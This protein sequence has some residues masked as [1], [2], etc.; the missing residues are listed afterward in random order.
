[1]ETSLTD[2]RP[3]VFL[4]TLLEMSYFPLTMSFVE[5]SA[6]AFGLDPAGILKL[7]LASEEIFSYLAGTDEKGKTVTIESEDGGY[8]VGV[9][10]LF[11]T[12][13]FDPHAFNFTAE[14]SLESEKGLAEMGLLIAS[15]SVNRLEMLHD[16]E[17]GLGIGLVKE[18]AYPEITDSVPVPVRPLEDFS[19][20]RP[21]RESLKLFV[22]Q[23]AAYYPLHHYPSY[24]RSPGKV[25][26][27]VEAGRHHVLVASDPGAGVA[28]GLM[29]RPA[30][31]KM[32]ALFGPYLFG[33]P[34]ENGMAEA[35]V[36]E[37][38]K[39]MAKADAVGVMDVFATPELPKD[40]F[41]LLGSIDYYGAQGEKEPLSYFFRQLKEDPGAHVWAH[42]DLAPFLQK[43]YSRLFLPRQILAPTL[44]GERRPPRSVFSPRFNRDQSLVVLRLVWD[45]T[46][47]DKVLEEHVKALSAEGFINIFFEMDL[48]YPWQSYLIPALSGGGFEPR[49]VLPYAGA[50]DIVVFEHGRGR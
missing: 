5:E 32:I 35:L 3:K 19:V 22:R 9:K 33:Q 8:Y 50:S 31:S 42:A 13:H 46:D 27:M 39:A 10:F 20:T 45:G 41:E 34:R 37:A 23:V 40:Y 25:V 29:W 16:S 26:D 15:R 28:G 48:A 43:E 4:T 12:R 44:E 7:R 30:G 18:K 24:F 36:E 6:A 11:E 14:A 49:M 17:T 1:M 21:D 38:L 2:R 47:A